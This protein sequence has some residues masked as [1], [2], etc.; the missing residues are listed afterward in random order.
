MIGDNCRKTRWSFSGI[1]GSVLLHD[2][3]FCDFTVVNNGNIIIDL[4][5]NQMWWLSRDQNHWSLAN[6]T[7]RKWINAFK[8]PWWESLICCFSFFTFAAL[9]VAYDNMLPLCATFHPTVIFLYCRWSR[10]MLS[11]HYLVCFYTYYP[12]CNTFRIWIFFK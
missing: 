1:F 10:L 5:K 6:V 12:F 2:F 7:N 3:D 8:T 9:P 11:L 4:T